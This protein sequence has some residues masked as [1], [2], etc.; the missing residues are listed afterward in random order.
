MRAMR[1]VLLA[2]AALGCIG[3]HTQSAARAS[4][5]PPAH[6]SQFV[7]FQTD[8]QSGSIKLDISTFD[9]PFLMVA[10]LENALGSND[11]GLDRAQNN[12]PL[13]V[14]FRRAGK[15]ALLVQLNTRF[16]AISADADEAK[17]A[18][19][20]FAESVLWAADV[21]ID[22]A[23]PKLVWVDISSLLLTDFVGVAER[24]RAT[25]QGDYR[26]DTAR[27]AAL[28]NTV[29]SFPD[30]ADFSSLLTFAGSG[31]GDYVRQIA[32][33]AKSLTVKQRL[34][35]M[36]LPAAGFKPRAY[37][38]A[39]GGFSIAYFDFAK[40]IESN[41][42]SRIQPRFRLEK[43]QPDAAR[44]T[45]VKPIVFY[46]DRGTPEPI[47]SALLEGANWWREA[48]DA[49][50][51]ID[52]FRA[53]L[54]PAHVDM[55]DARYN[56]ITWTHRATRGWSYGGGLIDPRTGEIIKGYVNLGS[57]R[58]RQ[59][60][61][62]AEGILAPY[63]KGADPGLLKEAQAMA[64]LRL[65]QLAAHEVGH[66]LG[67]AHNFAASR[68]GDGSVLDYPY[69]IVALGADGQPRLRQAYGVG[70]GE[71]D[72]FVVAHAY[73]VF[74]AATESAELAALR[75]AIKTA[76]YAYVSDADARSPGDAHEA[77]A[78]WDVPGGAMA[79]LT[80]LLRVRQIALSNFSAGALP[81]DRQL[82]D[83]ERRFVP[84]Y[85]L[86]RYQSEAVIRL[87]GG[88]TYSYGLIGDTAANT[89]S[90]AGTLQ[91]QALA[92]SKGLL[93]LETL[94][95]P[96]STLQV[97]TAPSNDYAR[98]S[99]YFGSRMAPVFDPLQAAASATALVATLAFDARRLN[100]LA[101]QHQQ[102]PNIPSTTALF[103]ALIAQSWQEKR[104]KAGT[105]L[106]LATRNWTLLD[107][108]LLT[109]DSGELH[110]T[111]AAEWR[112]SLRVLAAKLASRDGRTEVD[113]DRIEA[114][115]LIQRYLADPASVKLRALPSVPPGAPI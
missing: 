62:I 106:L 24:L 39:S 48:F 79:G 20:A 49:A 53:E 55:S 32:A 105:Q 13:L 33:D 15:R 110:P 30:N 11:I 8:P 75:S 38:P 43:T 109:L 83:A 36:R 14:E 71:W 27:S 104:S 94:T 100:R 37:H 70:I 45:V 84:M 101:W 10:T 74:P 68:T 19:D 23:S 76:G 103:D 87:I 40:A 60:L 108:A 12:E 7:R 46:L 96:A 69:P 3:L 9:Q 72:K 44:S 91:H 113:A 16:V 97:L 57:Q 5:T 65:R 85:L 95:I 58:V 26:L 35:F 89:Q 56:T 82:G 66:A 21:S 59:D 86:H 29:R 115:Q 63:R 93:S 34:S 52:A 22:K 2:I 50:G 6:S 111:V 99:E 107:A 114:A 81:P 54:A 78:L 42:E 92:A 31:E 112:N 47:R 67:F 90:V 61:L 1:N 25:K 51:F 102:D 88:S 77:G 98:N 18:R 80:H 17:A 4:K 64:L 73:G 28:A 41:L